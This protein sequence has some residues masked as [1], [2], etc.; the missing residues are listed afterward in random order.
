MSLF[1]TSSIYY[2]CT[3]C[4]CFLLL[5]R[6]ESEDDFSLSICVFSYVSEFCN[7]F[8]SHLCT[9]QD[10]D[11]DKIR[12]FLPCVRISPALEL[13][14]RTPSSSSYCYLP[15]SLY[16]S[17]VYIPLSKFS[18]QCSSTLLS[19]NI[20]MMHSTPALVVPFL[21]TS[22][23]INSPNT[24]YL[25]LFLFVYVN[26]FFRQ[27]FNQFLFHNI[28]PLCFRCI[29]SNFRSVIFQLL[30]LTFRD[31]FLRLVRFLKSPLLPFFLRVLVFRPNCLVQHSKLS[32][33][34]P[35][36]LFTSHFC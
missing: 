33:L 11:N 3:L 34:H 16:L 32:P 30:L 36:L 26:V 2:L 24:M 10:F 20:F 27:C 21:A 7:C 22:H 13:R 1:N 6:L 29:S 17:L 4:C 12:S 25:I 18:S 35:L 8:L 9:V 5:G 19:W 31:H 15:P 23:Y 28:D 14:L